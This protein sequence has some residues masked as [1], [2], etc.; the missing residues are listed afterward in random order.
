MVT[1]TNAAVSFFDR[2]VLIVGLILVATN[3]LFPVQI[4]V[5]RSLAFRSSCSTL[6]QCAAWAFSLIVF[7]LFT[8][9]VFLGRFGLKLNAMAMQTRNK[10]VILIHL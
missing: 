6:E 1:T 5:F 10:M 2:I 7:V 3:C 4:L 8:W 9:R